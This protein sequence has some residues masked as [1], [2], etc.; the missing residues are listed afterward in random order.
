ML[1]LIFAMF[2]T[3]C[4]ALAIVTLMAGSGSKVQAR[5]TQLASAGANL[6]ARGATESAGILAN[7]AKLASPA[8][9]LLSGKNDT[10]NRQLALAGYRKPH[11]ADVYFACRLLLPL[12]A[13]VT[14][15]SVFDSPMLWLVMGGAGFYVPTMWLTSAV[16]KRREQ[17]RVGLPDAIDLLV[18][19]MEAGLGIDQALVR[20]G[21]ELKVSYPMLSEELV[22]INQEQRAGKARIDAW[23]SM[24]E[25]TQLDT[26]HHFVSMLVQ[27]E[28]FG[29]PIARSLGQ[30]A[31]SLRLRRMQQAEE[32]AA[33]TTVKML[34]PLVACIFPAVFVVIL[35]PALMAFHRGFNQMFAK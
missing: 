29:T 30:F 27:T 24:G 8:Q 10:T 13:I 28:R 7:L 6:E 12:F 33:K 26:V 31:D 15:L 18:I 1:L 22:T 2:V 3:I 9:R 17:V 19:C 20:V 16:G 23:R 32:L 14:A 11:H 4:F 35:G 5:L 21:D 25:R 34:F